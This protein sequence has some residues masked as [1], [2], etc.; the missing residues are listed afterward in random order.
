[1]CPSNR[2]RSGMQSRARG[3]LAESDAVLLYDVS[4][5]WLSRFEQRLRPALVVRPVSSIA[6]LSE[7]LRHSPTSLAV[8]GLDAIGGSVPKM[9]ADGIQS[10]LLAEIRGRPV[11]GVYCARSP[12]P[13]SLVVRLIQGGFADILPLHDAAELHEVVAWVLTHRTSG[14]HSLVWERIAGYVAPEQARLVKTALRHAHA[15]FSVDELAK[16]LRCTDRTLRRHCATLGDGSALWLKAM[17]RLLLAGYL[18]D[19]PGRTIEDVADR[20]GFD[21]AQALREKVAKWTGLPVAVIQQDGWI[22]TL[23]P[24]LQQRPTR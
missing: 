17:S 11:L 9:R 1:M 21:S 19:Q 20:L 2:V 13:T 10:S 18:L 4:E 7:A 16:T 24:L 8:V 23:G 6:A 5:P 15:P 22:H 3:S 12:L 14:L